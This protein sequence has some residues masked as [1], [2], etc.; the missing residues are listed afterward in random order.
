L[1]KKGK[2]SL[3]YH[4]LECFPQIVVGN[5]RSERQLLVADGMFELDATRVQRDAAVG[6]ASGRAILEV[7]FDRTANGGQLAADLV[8][9]TR[10]QFYFEQ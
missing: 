7:A 2:F 5:G 9:P 10:E 6:I 3:P 4:L 8:M 1:T